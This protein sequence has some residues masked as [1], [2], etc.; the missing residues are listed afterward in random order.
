MTATAGPN[1]FETFFDVMRMFS[2][3]GFAAPDRLNQSILQGWSL[4]SV[5]QGN[6]SAPDTEQA[7]VA[8][9]SYGRQLGR[10]MDAL[11]VVIATS[12]PDLSGAA[13]QQQR[14]AIKDYKR[15]VTEV[16]DA[17]NMAAKARVGRLI[18]DLE[19]LETGNCAEFDSQCEA[20]ARF[21]KQAEARRAGRSTKDR[22]SD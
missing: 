9:A 6:S 21:L 8:K 2:P 19:S 7:V 18:A 13:H 11:D 1:P 14:K 12:L 3:V 20:L 4:I 10:I 17:K 22:P 16:K 5:N 15:L